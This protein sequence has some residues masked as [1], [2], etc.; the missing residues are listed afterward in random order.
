MI[1]HGE[2]KCLKSDNGPEFTNES[3]FLGVMRRS[4]ETGRVARRVQSVP[5]TQLAWQS[6]AGRNLA[7]V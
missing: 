7:N 6:N 4:G 3:L 2:P 5:T 1:M